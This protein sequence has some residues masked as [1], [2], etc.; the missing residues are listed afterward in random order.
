MTKQKRNIISFVKKILPQ[1]F[2]YAKIFLYNMWWCSSKVNVVGIRRGGVPCAST[3]ETD[4]DIRSIC[5][6]CSENWPLD[7]HERVGRLRHQLDPI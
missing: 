2:F 1:I 7:V 6:R 3:V 5:R 4:I